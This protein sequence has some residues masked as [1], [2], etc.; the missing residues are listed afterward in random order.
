MQLLSGFLA[1]SSMPAPRML[2][3]TDLCRMCE[4]AQ[5]SSLLRYD[6]GHAQSRSQAHLCL[7]S[8]ADCLSSVCVC[9]TTRWALRKNPI[10]TESSR[11]LCWYA[12]LCFVDSP[13]SY[14]C[15]LSS[16]PPPS[17]HEALRLFLNFSPPCPSPIYT[18]PF[19]PALYLLSILPQRLRLCLLPHLEQNPCSPPFYASFPQSA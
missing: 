5:F 12:H 19:L 13:C 1:P 3:E 6:C 15:T 14:S 8:D 9:S 16:R 10:E 11:G 2:T 18:F 17:F 4:D 7:F